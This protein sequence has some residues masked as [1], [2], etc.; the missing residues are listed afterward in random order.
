VME[1]RLIL[2]KQGVSS[3][4][5]MK[6]SPISI[7]LVEVPT[8][9]ITLRPRNFMDTFI[10]QHLQI[11]QELAITLKQKEAYEEFTTTLMDLISNAQMVDPK[12]VINLL[13]PNS[14]EKN[15]LLKG[16]ISPIMTKLRFHNKILGK[17]NVFNKQ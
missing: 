10:H 14:K 17:V 12:F 1:K 2:K 13:N 9:T 5:Y 8:I 15:I 11:I 16:K 3:K 4:S 7:S 6:R